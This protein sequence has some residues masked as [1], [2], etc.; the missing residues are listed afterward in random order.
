MKKSAKKI[1]KHIKKDVKEDKK[2]IK[3]AKPKSKPKDKMKKVME[4]YS[5]GKLRSGSKKGPVVKNPKQAVAIAYS[6]KKKEYKKKK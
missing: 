1:V 3:M 2:V 4:E 6:E 5:E